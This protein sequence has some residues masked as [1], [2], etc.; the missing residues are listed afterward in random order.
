MTNQDFIISKKGFIFDLSPWED[1]TPV[2]DINQKLG[3]DFETLK[4]ILLSAYKA[5]NKKIIAICGFVPW[6]KKYSSF[7]RS[8]GNHPVVASEWK[9]AET[10]S[11]YNAYIDADAI[12]FSGM[13][14]A[15]VFCHFP[16]DK[17]YKQP[18]PTLNTLKEKGFIDKDGKVKETTFICFYAGDY[19]SAAWTYQRLAFIWDDKNRGKTPMAWAVNPNLALRFPYGLHYYRKTATL[20]DFFIAGDSGAGYINP[21]YLEA[22]RK[23]S[24]LPSGVEVWREHCKYW[25]ERFDITLTGFLL[26]GNA[27]TMSDEL[28][29]AYTDFSPDGIGGMNMQKDGLYKEMPFVSV[30]FDVIQFDKTK[31]SDYAYKIKR[32]IGKKAPE[33]FM[34]RHILWSPSEQLD[35]INKLNQIC[36][37]SFEIVDPYTF[38]LLVKEVN[39]HKQAR[40]EKLSRNKF[41]YRKIKI[42]NYSPLFFNNDIRDMFGGEFGHAE[43]RVVLFE[44]KKSLNYTYFV[45]WETLN[46]I[47]FNDILLELLGDEGTGERFVDRFRIYKKDNLKDDWEEICNKTLIQPANG[48]FE[49]KFDKSLTGKYFRVEFYSAASKNNLAPRVIEIESY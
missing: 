12:N 34:Y 46:N 6:D 29:D 24:G 7:G 30:D 27:P 35:F 20:Q 1:E 41:D 19:D 3:V 13:A 38:M 36:P 48:I 14:N 32:S 40:I 26:E 33:F 17:I 44:D 45:E 5:N 25:Y 39:I 15:S 2:D 21:G 47:S 9:Y 37:D 43:K 49:I 28:W 42:T 22:P 4:Q 23:I 10:I 16:L 11:C 18:K 8:G 31:T